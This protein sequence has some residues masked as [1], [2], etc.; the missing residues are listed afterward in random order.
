MSNADIIDELTGDGNDDLKA[1]L[2]KEF[3][4]NN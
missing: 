2:L 1:E 4:T 3:T